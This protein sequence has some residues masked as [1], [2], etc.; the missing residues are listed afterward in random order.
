MAG[1]SDLVLLENE[2]KYCALHSLH[3]VDIRPHYQFTLA[4]D[5]KICLAPLASPHLAYLQ[6]S[7]NPCIIQIS[8]G[9]LH[10]YIMLICI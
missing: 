1:G 9:C 6:I 5:I 8:P 4:R 2:G 10:C 7:A 3:S